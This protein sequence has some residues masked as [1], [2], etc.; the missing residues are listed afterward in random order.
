MRSRC[1]AEVSACTHAAIGYVTQAR[2][3]SGPVEDVPC[4]IQ[5]SIDRQSAMRTFMLPV[6]EFLGH[7]QNFAPPWIAARRRI[8]SQERGRP[9][10]SS[11][12][13]ICW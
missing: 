8:P 12:P 6:T 10:G 1:L 9:S 7:I 4:G 11:A 5:I 13:F 2:A 3:H